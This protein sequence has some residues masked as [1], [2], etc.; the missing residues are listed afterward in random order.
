MEHERTIA[1]ASLRE[2]FEGNRMVMERKETIAK[3]SFRRR[4]FRTSVIQAQPQLGQ[5]QILLRDSLIGEGYP[6]LCSP[7]RFLIKFPL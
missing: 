1:K 7:L 4:D 6:H 2:E 5:L 3:A